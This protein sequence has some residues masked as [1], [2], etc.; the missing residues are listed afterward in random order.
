MCIIFSE[1]HTEMQAVGSA[2][3]VNTFLQEYMAIISGDRNAVVLDGIKL[4][5]FRR[6]CVLCW[7]GFVHNV[8]NYL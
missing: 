8:L 7:S 3:N 4:I 2:S 5:D 6:C 1:N